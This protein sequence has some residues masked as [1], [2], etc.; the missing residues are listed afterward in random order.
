MSNVA[1]GTVWNLPNYIGEIFTASPLETPILSMCGGL[2]GLQQTNNFEFPVDQLFAH[3]AASQPAITETASLTKK[4]AIS[5]VRSQD[6]NVC[7][8]HQETV[9]LSYDKLANAGRLSGLSTS[10]EVVKPVNEI[11]WQVMVVLQ[12][13][14][15]DVEFSFIQGVYQK[16]TSESVANKTR[17]LN[18]AAGTTLD[19]NGVQLSKKLINQILAAAYANGA[20][21][22][23]SIFC[24]NAFQKQV[25]SDIYAYAPMDRNI[26]GV[27]L[28]Q[29]E[30]DFGPVGI[31]LDPFQST[32]VLGIYDMTFVKAVTQPIPGKGNMF[33]EPLGKGG[34]SEDSQIFG[35]IGL[36]HG[37][38]FR[39]ATITNLTTS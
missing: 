7:Q 23:N 30:T 12:K 33:L 5:Y 15:R 9:S 31:V 4:T 24:V 20:R 27:N 26:G 1:A 21:F 13:I 14:A 19:A 8:T 28:K 22:P 34:A 10:G 3:E 38:A 37:P 11:D 16:A 39:H 18:A 36:N 6:S 35:K 2:G 29:I 25:L 17:G 32:S